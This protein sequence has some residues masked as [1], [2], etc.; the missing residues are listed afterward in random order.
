M[1]SPGSAAPSLRLPDAGSGAAVTDPWTGGPVVLAFFKTTCP[2]CHM[3]APKVQALAEA[4]ARVIGIGQ[5]PPGE[6]AAYAEMTGQLVPTLSESEPYPV[7]DA[8]GLST[9]PAMFLVGADGVIADAVAGWD[10]DGW[11]RLAEAAGVGPVSHEGDGLPSF[12]PG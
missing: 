8:F 2:V 3:S 5:D 11:N 9:V 12:R 4:G 6:I 10:R 7:S 1:L